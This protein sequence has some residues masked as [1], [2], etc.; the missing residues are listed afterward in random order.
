MSV[1]VSLIGGFGR[2][3][4]QMRPPVMASGFQGRSS[5]ASRTT[6]PLSGLSRA[7]LTP[8]P[9]FPASRLSP[10]RLFCSATKRASSLP[11]MRPSPPITCRRPSLSVS[12]LSQMPA[13]FPFLS[14]AGSATCGCGYF[15]PGEM[16]FPGDCPRARPDCCRA[17]RPAAASS[18]AR[19]RLNSWPAVFTARSLRGSRI[20]WA[21]AFSGELF[22][23]FIQPS[24]LSVYTWTCCFIRDNP[25]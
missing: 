19:A 5:P 17:A 7:I 15:L 16:N 8:S 25:T 24:R 23:A 11:M 10:L 14:N 2:G 12:G 6:T 18:S 21:V 1:P 20:S 4:A 3:S 22:M 13:S 9:I